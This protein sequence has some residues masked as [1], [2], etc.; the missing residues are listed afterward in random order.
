MVGRV[1]IEVTTE[2]TDIVV[3]TR[4]DVAVANFHG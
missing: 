3:E 1:V 4:F 2:V